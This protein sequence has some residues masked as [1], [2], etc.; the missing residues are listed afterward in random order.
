[1]FLHLRDVVAVLKALSDRQTQVASFT[2]V[3]RPIRQKHMHSF[4]HN[5]FSIGF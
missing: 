4:V 2:S 1:M 5:S 3:L